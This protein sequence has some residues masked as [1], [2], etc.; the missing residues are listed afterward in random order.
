M[1]QNLA[2][3]ALT[4]QYWDAGL[5]VNLTPL[6]LGVRTFLDDLRARRGSVIAISSVHAIRVRTDPGQRDPARPDPH[7]HVGRHRR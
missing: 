4:R 5:A 1:Q 7:P 2:A 3:H 6:F